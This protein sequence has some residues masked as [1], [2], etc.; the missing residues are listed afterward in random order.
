MSHKLRS[1][2]SLDPVHKQWRALRSR[3]A[4][5]H[6]LRCERNGDPLKQPVFLVTG[7][8]QSMIGGQQHEHAW[9]MVSTPNISEVDSPRI[10]PL[11]QCWG[12]NK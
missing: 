8:S 4:D 1:L 10:Q 6:R 11:P 2:A 5:G 3:P 12:A 9:I 7:Y